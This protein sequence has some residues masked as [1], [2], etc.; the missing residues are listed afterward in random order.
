MLFCKSYKNL[1]PVALNLREFDFDKVKCEPSGLF[2][3]RLK[4]ATL[5]NFFRLFGNE[6]QIWLPLNHSL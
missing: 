1:G 5:F 6:F 2:F 3:A 4:A